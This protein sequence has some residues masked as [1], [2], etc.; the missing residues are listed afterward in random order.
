[1][2]TVISTLLTCQRRW[3]QVV[4][5]TNGAKLA[6]LGLQ[7]G[8]MIEGVPINLSR[9][10][11]RDLDAFFATPIAQRAPLGRPSHQTPVF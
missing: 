10:L 9:G 5:P 11:P 6:R 2:R 8:H 7:N 3:S 4:I 1:M